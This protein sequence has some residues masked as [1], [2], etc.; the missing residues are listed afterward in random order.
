[1]KLEGPRIVPWGTP[2]VTNLSINQFKHK[3]VNVYADDTSFTFA[4]ADLNRI[5][6]KT[7]CLYG[8]QPINLLLLD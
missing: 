3:A 2:H 5:S 7:G 8:Y 4:S 1:M 6:D